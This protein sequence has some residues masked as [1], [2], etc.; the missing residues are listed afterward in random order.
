[1]SDIGP[2]GR[3]EAGALNQPGRPG[4]ASSSGPAA[5]SAGRE[6]DAVELSR[7]AYLMSRLEAMPDIRQELV[8]SVR[9]Q[10]ADGT[11]ETPERLNAAIEELIASESEL[12]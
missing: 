1:M 3:P 2:V 12:F 9:Q 7:T 11:Y 6:G 4:P 8:D 10:I 5:R